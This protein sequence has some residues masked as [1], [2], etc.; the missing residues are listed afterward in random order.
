MASRDEKTSLSE[1]NLILQ[2]ATIDPEQAK[3]YLY[4]LDLEMII[5]RDPTSGFWWDFATQE[6]YGVSLD[7]ESIRSG[8]ILWPENEM[9]PGVR[10]SL[11]TSK[12]LKNISFWAFGVWY[13]LHF[14]VSEC[15]DMSSS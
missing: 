14:I 15:H 9:T 11:K 5:A 3:N 12:K 6:L 2:Q 4:V 10:K 13:E 7:P 1:S 8:K